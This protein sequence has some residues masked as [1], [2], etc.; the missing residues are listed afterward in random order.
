MSG[1]E[2]GG[3]PRGSG[4]EGWTLPPGITEPAGLDF[5]GTAHGSSSPTLKRQRFRS[6]QPRARVVRVLLQSQRLRL[7]AQRPKT[8]HVLAAQP[9][10]LDGRIGAVKARIR[11]LLRGTLVTVASPPWPVDPITARVL[12]ATARDHWAVPSNDPSRPSPVTL[13]D[14]PPP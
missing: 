2:P 7:G 8:L 1:S 11:A 9:S 4:P 13:R 14:W 10:A 6:R 12:A 5:L 3:L